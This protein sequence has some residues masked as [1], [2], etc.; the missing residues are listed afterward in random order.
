M[1]KI[2]LI[3]SRLNQRRG[4]FRGRG[5]SGVI[6]ASETGERRE[7]LNKARKSPWTGTESVLGAFGTGAGQKRQGVKRGLMTE[8]SKL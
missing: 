6:T 8:D 3:I 5:H 1:A 7:G 2:I 4:L